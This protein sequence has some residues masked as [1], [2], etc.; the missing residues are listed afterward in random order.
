M[1]RILRALPCGLLAL[2]LLAF[3]FMGATAHAKTFTIVTG[4]WPPFVS[5][6]MEGG[7]PMARL[8]TEAVEAAG[9]EV[10]F[11][12]MPWA[13]TEAMTQ[14]GNALATFPWSPT[15]RFKETCHLSTPLA[16]QRMVVFFL[17]DKLPD[18]DYTSLDNLK[19]Y[20][21]GGSRGYSYV[22]LFSRAGITADYAPDVRLSFK[23]LFADRVDLVPENDIVGWT[24]LEQ[25]FPEHASRVASSKTALYEAPLHL[26]I[27]KTHPDGTE[28][29]ELFEHGLGMLDASGR[30]RQILEQG[31]L[32]RERN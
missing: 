22:E 20:R 30:T 14:S 12:F 27:S 10:V 26:M 18:W 24:I 15:T 29:H 23:K 32:I 6:H 16:L 25:E 31:N 3:M 7:G 4:E 21:V 5:E 1:Y 19:N 13:R 9:H 2:G 11:S 28:F 8:V 17:Q